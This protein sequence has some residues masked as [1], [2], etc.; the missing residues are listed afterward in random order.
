[1]R[2]QLNSKH[3]TLS[4]F[5]VLVLFIPFTH[6]HLLPFYEPEPLQGAIV[7]R[8]IPEF[9]TSSWFDGSFQDS[10]MLYLNDNFGFRTTLIRANNQFQYSVFN[11]IKANSVIKGQENYLYEENYLKAVTGLDFIGEQKIDS[12]ARDLKEATEILKDDSI[13]LIIV[14]APGKGTYC[15]DY[16]PESYAKQKTGKSN[17]LSM[18]KAFDQQKLNVIDFQDWFLSMRDTAT[19]P[20][21]PM[22][23]IHWSKWGEFLAADSLVNYIENLTHRSL[24]HFIL[25]STSVSEENLDTD[26]DIGR[27]L[28]LLWPLESFPMTYPHWHISQCYEKDTV[29]VVSIADSYY[30]G[31]FNIGVSRDLFGNGQFWFYNE[32]I[33]PDSYDKPLFTSDIDYA[34]ALR[35]YDVVVLL[36]TDANLPRMPYGFAAK[37]KEV[38]K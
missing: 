6:Q 26:Y 35:P 13:E 11:R 19:I 32:Q 10:M 7:E 9:R 30:W 15:E 14:F 17:Y 3:T 29:R 4:I 38:M 16:I 23:G 37:V 33:F 25:D 28:N 8:K 34:A 18:R 1:M 31:M 5:I 21:Y 20:L 36:F 22:C 2:Q 12:I 27:G 24:P